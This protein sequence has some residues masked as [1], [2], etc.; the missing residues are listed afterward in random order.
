VLAPITAPI[1]VTGNGISV[2][3]D[4]TVAQGS[5]AASAPAQAPA[6]DAMTGGH[7]GILSGTQVLAPI[8]APITVTGNGISVLGDSTVAQGSDAASA[9]AQ[10]PATDA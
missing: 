7:D 9:P 5:D 2:L 3:G 8:T 4:S 6:T 1:T 10:A